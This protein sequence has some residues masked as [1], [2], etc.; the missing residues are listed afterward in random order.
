MI[1]PMPDRRAAWLN[2][3]SE[4]VRQLSVQRH[5]ENRAP[6]FRPLMSVS[7]CD[8]QPVDE[9]SA[10]VKGRRLV[11]KRP[12]QSLL[13]SFAGDCRVLSAAGTKELAFRYC[14]LPTGSQSRYQSPSAVATVFRR[15]SGKPAM[16]E[17]IGRVGGQ[18]QSHS[19]TSHV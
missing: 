8:S 17:I 7:A 12:T 3:W 16:M 2:D 14:M 1:K 9:I 18:G 15:Q 13:Q 11:R 10:A 4:L 19:W 5:A 6:F